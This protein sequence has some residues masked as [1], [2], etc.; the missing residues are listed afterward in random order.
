[1]Y[2]THVHEDIVYLVYIDFCH[3]A[4]RLQNFFHAQLN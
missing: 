1:M 3:L 2:F 4:P